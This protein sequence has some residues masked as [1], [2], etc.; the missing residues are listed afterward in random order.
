MS[1]ADLD[2]LKQ[3]I[4]LA[5]A[6]NTP[7]KGIGEIVNDYSSGSALIYRIMLEF[8]LPILIAIAIGLFLDKEF[9]TA[10]LFLVIFILLGV[11]SGFMNIY[12]IASRDTQQDT[13]QK[14]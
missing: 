1:D 3:K 12:R 2:K 10:P 13:S 6:R 7:K 11:G 5:K 8:L 14:D 4:D 9:A